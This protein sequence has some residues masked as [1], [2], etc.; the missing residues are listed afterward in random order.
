L[1]YGIMDIELESAAHITM[2]G[3]SI[4]IVLHHKGKP[5]PVTLPSGSTLSDLSSH[6]SETLHIPLSNQKYLGLPGVSGMLKPP[7]DEATLEKH[8]LPRLAADLSSNKKFKITLLGSTVSDVADLSA[9]ISKAAA[10]VNRTRGP[11]SAVRPRRTARSQD[12]LKYSFHSIRPL[13]WLPKPERSQAFLERLA[14]D[15]GIKAAMRKWEFSVGLLTEM[16]PSMHTTSES[17]TLGLNRNKG[18]VIELRLRTDAYDGYRDYKTIRKTLCHELTHNIWSD[19]DQNFWKLCKEV[20]K[21]VAQEDW[22][23]G[24]KSVGGERTYEPEEEEDDHHVDGGGWT[25]GEYVVGR[26]PN[27]SNP[28]ASGLSRREIIARATEERIKRQNELQHN[29]PPGDAS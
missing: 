16:D 12:D 24:G 29:L 11:I 6:I 26:N 28:E 20:E 4:N 14:A 27:A 5:V 19:H 1:E 13:T 15:P 17:R 9:S 2:D 18:E 7:F 3:D 22:T 25:G 10:A 8:P 23:R 21:Y